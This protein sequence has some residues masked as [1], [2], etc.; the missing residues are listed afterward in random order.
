MQAV[1]TAD[2][3]QLR[4]RVGLSQGALDVLFDGH[5]VWSVDVEE[6]PADEHGMRV[7]RWPAPLAQR[8]DGVAH[9]SLLPHGS[10]RVLVESPCT[11]GS[12]DEPIDLRD[13]DGGLLSLSKWGRLNQSFADLD[14][15][16]M[17]RYLDQAMDVLSVLSDELGLPAFVAYGTM[18]GAARSGRLIGHDMDIDLAYLSATSSPVDAMLESFRVE[19]HLR[20]KGWRLKRQNGG[21]LQLFFEQG[22]ARWRNIDVFTMVVDPGVPRLY[23]INDIAWD[24][25]VDVVLPLGELG[26]EGRRWPAPRR[27][28]VLCEAAYGPSWKVPDPSFEYGMHPGKRQMRQWFGGFR[29]DHDAWVRVYRDSPEIVPR[30]PTEFAEWVQPSLADADLVV[31]AGCGM[32]RDTLFYSTFRPAVVGLDVAESGVRRATRRARRAGVDPTFEVVNFGVLRQSSVTAACLAA[33]HPGRRV[34]VARH[35]LDSMSEAAR[36]NFFA[37]C[38]GVCRPGG[39]AIVQFCTDE[40]DR[41]AAEFPGLPKRPMSVEQVERRASLSGGTVG[42]VTLLDG[43]EGESCRMTLTWT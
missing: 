21:F 17:N 25:D 43:P 39:E 27:P 15:A 7:A 18:L 38:A 41:H 3:T 2:E 28:D 14:E 5:R 31:D 13:D 26:L 32:G 35:L 6:C 24:V 11:F 12:S 9:L 40:S 1:L 10:D 30:T 37:F 19:R 36:D 42:S 22:G 23:G 33:Y 34:V 29:E 20:A 8:L 4:F 16:S